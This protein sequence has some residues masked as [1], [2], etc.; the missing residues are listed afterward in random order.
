V[1]K[2]QKCHRIQQN[3]ENEQHSSCCLAGYDYRQVVSKQIPENK[4]MLHASL[5]GPRTPLGNFWA[6]TQKFKIQE[7]EN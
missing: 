6:E 1:Q 3:T 2:S 5:G 7:N 4:L